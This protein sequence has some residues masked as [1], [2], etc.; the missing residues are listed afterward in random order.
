MPGERAARQREA[1]RA[2]G[3]DSRAFR[4]REHAAIDAAHDDDEQHRHRPHAPERVE[5]LAPGG[6]LAAR[7]R[8][9]IGPDD[10]L[11]R[12]AQENGGQDARHDAGGEQLADIGLGEHA[13]DHHDGRGR[14]ENSERA[15][16]GDCPGRQA[17]RVAE[18][19]HRRIGDLGHGGGGRDR[20]AADGAEAGAGTDR[21]HG[22]AA[23]QMADAG[24][25]CAEQLLRHAGA[26]DEV[27]HE[28]EQGHHRQRI[29]AARLV[30]LGLHHR[31]RR[32]EVPVAQI[33]DAEKTDDAHRDGDRDAQQ[34]QGHHQTQ[35]DQS[36]RHV[37][38][39]LSGSNCTP[40][41][42][43][44]GKATLARCTIPVTA[45]MMAMK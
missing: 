10:P 19:F 36:F 5:P 17:V 15:A 31:Q 44:A 14:N 20:G 16:A 4:R 32:G 43:A 18:V 22:K 2:E 41:R 12:E 21:R 6:A 3:T 35:A 27:A 38:V 28:Y 33:G 42:G 34:R 29:V 30:D 25:G 11:H 39:V 26:R 1:E 24:V 40:V 37:V 23:A 7:P 8:G 9:R 13:V 45:T